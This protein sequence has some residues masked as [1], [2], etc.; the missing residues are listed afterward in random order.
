M[1]VVEDD[2]F[3]AA[4]PYT[5][6]PLHHKPSKLTLETYMSPPVLL[7]QSRPVKSE[8]D[9]NLSKITRVQ[10]A[11]RRLPAHHNEVLD[12]RAARVAS[13]DNMCA[14]EKLRLSSE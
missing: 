8:L 5:L 10:E 9:A 14:L 7:H 13:E 4:E 6:L 2:M 11:S 12:L 3:M 1:V